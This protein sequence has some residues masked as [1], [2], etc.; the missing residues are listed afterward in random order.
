MSWT[1]WIPAGAFALGESGSAVFFL[2]ATHHIP[3]GEANLI[4]YLWPGMIIGFEA[5]LG[6]VQIETASH[7]RLASRFCGGSGPDGRRADGIF[8]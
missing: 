5:A 8:L 4:P 7:P 1:S 2:L 6:L 3:T